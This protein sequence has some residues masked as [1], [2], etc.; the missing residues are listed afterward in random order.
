MNEPS[1]FSGDELTMN[2]DA[3]HLRSDGKRFLHKDLHNAYG[4]FMN[5]ATY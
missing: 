4:L 2:K 3:V 1:V 5:S